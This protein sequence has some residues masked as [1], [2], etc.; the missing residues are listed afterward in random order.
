ME[1]FIAD[2][3]NHPKVP[4]LIRYGIVIILCLFIAVIG[5]GCAVQSPLV[6]GKLFGLSL[7]IAIFGIGIYLS[8]S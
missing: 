1:P 3:I 6:W 7:T 4:K 8:K 2:L 5:I